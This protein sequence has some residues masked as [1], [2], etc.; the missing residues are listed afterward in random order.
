MNRRYYNGQ[1]S[2]VKLQKMCILQ[3]KIFVTQACKHYLLIGCFSTVL[4]NSIYLGIQYFIV[5]LSNHFT[6]FPP[7]Y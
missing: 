2:S 5:H 7:Y 3:I 6:F 4:K 1:I